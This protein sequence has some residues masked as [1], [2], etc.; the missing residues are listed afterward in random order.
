M[1]FFKDRDII[2]VW[3]PPGHPYL[4]P[5]EEVWKVLKG[6]VDSSIR[7]ADLKSHLAAVYGFINN[8]H[9]F[10]YDFATFW[11]RRPSKGI[12]RP[13]IRLEGRQDP[14]KQVVG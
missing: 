2:L 1:E 7:Y 6:A 11:R 4:N 3:Y 10:D 13:I 8:K 5:V 12:M 14:P 9:R